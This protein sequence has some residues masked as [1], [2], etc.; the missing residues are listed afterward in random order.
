MDYPCRVQRWPESR[1]IA[2]DN[3]KSFLTLIVWAHCVLELSV[4]VKG[5]PGG[6]IQFIKMEGRAPQVI[7]TWTLGA[8]DPEVFLLDST[9]KVVLRTVPDDIEFSQLDACERLVLR[10]YGSTILRREF[11][12]P[13]AVQDSVLLDAVQYV[14]FMAIITTK[15][16]RT[17][18]ADQSHCQYFIERWQIFE[19]AKSIFESLKIDEGEVDAYID[20]VSKTFA[21]RPSLLILPR[22]GVLATYLDKKHP[23]DKRVMPV[24][25]RLMRL[26]SFVVKIAS[27]S[28]IETGMCADMPLLADFSVVE[29]VEF[30]SRVQRQEGFVS[31]GPC[32]PLYPLL[33]IAGWSSLHRRRS[34]CGTE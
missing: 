1:R 28:G 19:A 8:S 14:I 10:D 17:E 32:G 22:P 21:K 5:I 11:N 34:S 13:F 26:A 27:I 24:H 15:L 9:M 7:I 31:Y 33:S 20:L 29:G 2:I 4:V 25:L 30:V 6:D 12:M 23:G 16:V 3:Q 18:S